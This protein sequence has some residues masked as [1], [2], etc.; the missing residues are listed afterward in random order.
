MV[1]LARWKFKQDDD[2]RGKM[3]AFTE[4][5]ASLIPRTQN[6]G[7][8]LPCLHFEPPGDAFPIFL[9]VSEFPIPL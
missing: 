7:K 6:W 4:K 5:S 9:S 2:T 8:Q 3:T 1:P